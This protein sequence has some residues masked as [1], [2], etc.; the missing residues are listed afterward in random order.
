MSLTA[1][2]RPSIQEQIMV[3]IFGWRESFDSIYWFIPERWVQY[4]FGC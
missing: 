4:M 1:I 2:G 3:A